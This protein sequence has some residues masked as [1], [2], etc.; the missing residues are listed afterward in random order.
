[1]KRKFSSLLLVAAIASESVAENSHESF[2]IQP[3]V[4]PELKLSTPS[5]QP[6]PTSSAIGDSDEPLG[7][8]RQ[9]ILYRRSRRAS[10]SKDRFARLNAYVE[11]A[12]ELMHLR[13]LQRAERQMQFACLQDDIESISVRTRGCHDFSDALPAIAK[14]LD[15]PYA[16]APGAIARLFQK[17]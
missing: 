2:L 6:G 17:F 4:E 3:H 10:L 16:G 11:T 1:M 9:K 14:V 5:K 13:R 8:L 12:H 7:I 15:V